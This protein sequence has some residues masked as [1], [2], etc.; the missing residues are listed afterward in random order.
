MSRGR[1][2]RNRN[3]CAAGRSFGIRARSQDRGRRKGLK[4]G[5]APIPAFN[6][7]IFFLKIIFF[8]VRFNII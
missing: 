2:V 3:W 7:N 4:C 1:K 6:P 8:K 5:G